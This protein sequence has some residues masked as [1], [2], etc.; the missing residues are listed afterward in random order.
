MSKELPNKPRKSRKKATQ[1]DNIESPEQQDQLPSSDE[2]KIDSSANESVQ[3]VVVSANKRPLLQKTFIQNEAIK[4]FKKKAREILLVGG[5]RS[6]KTFIII[7]R[8]LELAVQNPGS[9]HLIARYRF[10]HVKNSVWADTLRKVVKLGF[11]DVKVSWRRSDYYLELENGS[12]IWLAGLD[13]K[14]RTEKIL[15]M[16]FLTVFLNEASQISY[17]AYTTIKTRLAQLIAG[18]PPMLFVDANPPGKK[19]WL[20]QVFIRH[21]EPEANIKL[22]PERYASLKMNPDQNLSNI[23]KDYMDTLDSLP[24]RKR[25][26][27][28]D[29]E[30]ADETEG[31]LW[32]DDLVNGLRII[33]PEDGTLPVSLKRIVI[34]IDPAVST[35]DTSDE[36]GIVAA[37]IGFDGH[38]YV[39][40][41]KTDHYKPTEWAQQ[42]IAL[43]HHYRADRIIGE[44]NNGGDLIETVLRSIDSKISYKSVHATR[45]KLTRAEP[46]AALY[47]Q[48]KAHHIGQLLELELEM[49]SWEAKKAERSP[50]RI[51]AL[52]WAATELCLTDDNIIRGRAKFHF[53]KYVRPRTHQRK[54]LLNR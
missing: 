22:K 9:R 21:I 13:D 38:L 1:T 35:K 39:I 17:G 50:N 41:D 42:A 46:V 49:T 36:T 37:G 8:Q 10:N 25:K 33:R 4:L 26:R 28:R 32:T 20:Y 30:F 44:V 5:S 34:A 52:V 54:Y 7:Y 15:G 45:D 31:A 51:D 23:S 18:V 16:E 11:P 48:G 27:F 24:L 29:G 19:H 6:G 12:Q 43:Y 53:R 40:E 2:V 14:D 47:E 3:P